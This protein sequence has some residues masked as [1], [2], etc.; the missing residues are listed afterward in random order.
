M[1]RPWHRRVEKFG[2]DTVLSGQEY[3]TLIRNQMYA[4]TDSA[5][6]IFSRHMTD[7]G[8]NHPDQDDMLKMNEVRGVR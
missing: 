4:W 8:R 7:D 2:G 1:S 6:T 3:I 5:M